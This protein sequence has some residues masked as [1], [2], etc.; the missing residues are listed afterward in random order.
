M[1][2]LVAV[3]L[4]P[5]SRILCDA[6][7]RAT[8]WLIGTVGGVASLLLVLLVARAV[9]DKWASD[10][11]AQ[12]LS[13]L[14]E[15]AEPIGLADLARESVPAN[16]DADF[17]LRRC[18]DH[19]K[20]IIGELHPAYD[21]HQREFHDDDLPPPLQ[22]AIDRA[23]QTHP[24]ALAL[25]EK[26][27]SCTA[28]DH[29]WDTR[30]GGHAFLNDNLQRVECMHNVA[31]VV[32]I[33]AM[34]SLARAQPED[35]LN[36][37]I[38]LF[39]ICRLHQRETP[40]VSFLMAMAL[41]YAAIEASNT[42]LQTSSLPH[43]SREALEAE[44]RL[45]DD[46]RLLHSVFP[47]ER[48]LGLA[49]FQDSETQLVHPKTLAWWWP[50]MWKNDQCAYLDK[51]ANQMQASQRP[52][53]DRPRPPKVELG[54]SSDDLLANFAASPSVEP[55]SD[56]LTAS[57][58]AVPDVVDRATAELRCLRLINQLTRRQQAG[59]DREP[60][61]DELGLPADASVDP[62]NGETLRVKK[63]PGGWLVYSVGTNL[64][65]DGGKLADY[66]DV[67]LGPIETAP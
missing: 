23:L 18:E 28:F 64:K 12:K 41:R 65:D 29:Q 3:R 39:R 34:L 47:V 50:A 37:A 7:K 59:H 22:E 44:L 20:A 27:G 10:R 33:R 24:D 17:Y 38:V 21:E 19:V 6:M 5:K 62:Y 66:E 53:R 32:Q 49:I 16:E 31:R 8:R 57:L 14:T 43:T 25:I 1:W 56:L 40:V 52:F 4:K 13:E 11:L 35:A 30:S 67:G 55:L 2:L 26:A 61:L 9:A 51:M 15:A 36:R 58:P 63:L 42:I 46:M 45:H 60:R 54:N 48:A